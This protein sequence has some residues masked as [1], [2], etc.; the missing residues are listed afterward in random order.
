MKKDGGVEVYLHAY[1]AMT[2]DG[3]GWSASQPSR[4]S[5]RDTA[6]GGWIAL[7]PVCTLWGGKKSLAQPEIEP[8]LGF[9]SHSLVAIEDCI[10][11]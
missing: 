1:L 11:Y 2:L 4:F 8:L 10:M 5:P 3:D 9:L 7:W 6:P